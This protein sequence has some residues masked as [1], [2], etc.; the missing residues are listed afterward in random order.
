MGI[1]VGGSLAGARWVL[2]L[3]VVAW[4]V[5][6]LRAKNILR[7]P[8]SPAEP[9]AADPPAKGFARL[10]PIALRMLVRSNPIPHIL[11]DVRY[12]PEVASKPLPKELDNAVSLPEPDVA[13]LLRALKTSA[14]T[15]TERFGKHPVPSLRTMLV[16]VC[17]KGSKA[18]RAAATAVSLGFTRCTVLEG[19]VTAYEAIE[20]AEP[21]LTYINRDAMALLLDRGPKTEE[22]ADAQ[23]VLIDL[24]RHDER[25]LFG[26]IPGAVHIP[27]DQWPLALEKDPEEWCRVHR[28]PKPAEEDIIILHSRTGRRAAWAAQIAADFGWKHCLVYRQGTYGWRLDPTVKSYASF[29]LGDVPPEPE[30]FE[31]DSVDIDSAEA[32]LRALGFM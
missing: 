20:G 19:G 10:S 29:Q 30:R 32:E 5:R 17:D 7:Q 25:I 31:E 28:F 21:H 11:V 26:S 16:F 3:S 8:P 18:S 4:G 13:A 27:A 9:P 22:H 6:V 1:I 24:R 14:G 2:A 12:P 15:W 23:L